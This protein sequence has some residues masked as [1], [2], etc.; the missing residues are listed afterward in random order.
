MHPDLTFVMHYITYRE[1]V[2]TND[3]TGKQLALYNRKIC[4]VAGTILVKP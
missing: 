3:L 4:A 1:S 2:Y